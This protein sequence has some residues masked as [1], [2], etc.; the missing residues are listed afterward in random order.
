MVRR[1]S[2]SLVVIGGALLQLRRQ[3]IKVAVVDFHTE[4]AGYARQ[5]PPDPAEAE[6]A[7]LLTLQRHA[8][9]L[10]GRPAFPFAGADHPLPLTGAAGGHQHQGEGAFGRGEGENLRRVRHHDAARVGGGDVD[11]VETDAECG[12]D[13]RARRQGIDADGIEAFPGSPQDARGAGLRRAAGDLG[14]VR[15]PGRV[16]RVQ[17]G[18]VILGG[19]PRSPR[20][21]CG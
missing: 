9:E 16:L 11:M 18:I 17:A 3:A 15:R 14:A 13:L 5:F 21:A 1:K 19:A 6:D 4:A 2:S 8:Q 20:A 7:E 12:D 10:G